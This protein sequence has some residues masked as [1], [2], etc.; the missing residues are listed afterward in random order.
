[1]KGIGF[2]AGLSCPNCKKDLHIKVGKNGPFLACSG[3][4]DCT[5]S[6]DYTRDEKGKIQPIDVATGEISDKMCDRCGKPMV[7]KQGKYGKFLA[8]SGYPDCN[9][10]Q[11]LNANGNGK[12]IGVKCPEKDC[13]GN[14]VRRQSR[15][16]KT[17]YGCSRFPSCSFA[18]WDKP[19]AH[20]CP[21]CGADFLVEK[22]TKK[23]GTFLACITEGCG[24]KTEST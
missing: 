8:C 13:T 12:A 17:F 10:T 11:S 23:S 4:P 3:Y 21:K 14:I 5:Y 19:T 20:P 18:T 24:Y 15:R 16:G 2:P 6:R 9:H 22:S 1:M 7:I